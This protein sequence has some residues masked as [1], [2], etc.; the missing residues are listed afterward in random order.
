VAIGRV[1]TNF[2]ASS[3]QIRSALSLRASD[4]AVTEAYAVLSS[5]LALPSTDFFGMVFV[6]VALTTI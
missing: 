5:D 4:F 2:S 1:R 3:T 6:L